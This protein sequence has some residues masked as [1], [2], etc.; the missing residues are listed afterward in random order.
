MK[1][2]KTKGLFLTLIGLASVFLFTS[3]TLNIESAPVVANAQSSIDYNEKTITSSFASL[4]GKYEE[5]FVE[6]F[7]PFL[8]SHIMCNVYRFREHR[9]DSSKSVIL[10]SE[11]YHSPI[12][13]N[14]EVKPLEGCISNTT[15]I[16][17]MTS[18]EIVYR[19]AGVLRFDTRSDFRHKGYRDLYSNSLEPI[20]TFVLDFREFYEHNEYPSFFSIETSPHRE[21]LT[22]DSI[23]ITYDSDLGY[24]NT[25]PYPSGYN[26]HRLPAIKFNTTNTKYENYYFN[27]DYSSYTTE[28]PLT[29]SQDTWNFYT[30]TEG[31]NSISLYGTNSHAFSI[32]EPA[33]YTRNDGYVLAFGD[34]YIQN[35]TYYEFDVPLR[36]GKG[37]GVGRLVLFTQGLNAPG[38]IGEPLLVFTD[39]H[40]ATFCE[41]LN[42]SINGV[43]A[44]GPR[45]D[46]EYMK[47]GRKW[48]PAHTVGLANT[49]TS[50]KPSELKPTITITDGPEVW[51]NPNESY[52][53]NVKVEDFAIND[54]VTFEVLE[55][56][57]KT[58]YPGAGGEIYNN[59]A[60]IAKIR[61]VLEVQNS[62]IVKSN[63]ITVHASKVKELKVSGTPLKT[64]YYDGHLFDPTGLE[65]TA[66][67]E[68][69]SI[70]NVSTDACVW[71]NP[72]Y[73]DEYVHLWQSSINCKYK[74]ACT[75][76]NIPEIKTIYGSDP[77]SL[78]IVQTTGQILAKTK[79]KL[80]VIVEP[81][82]AGKLV[83]WSIEYDRQYSQPAEIDKSGV[84]S[85]KDRLCKFAVVATSIFDSSVKDKVYFE[86]VNDVGYG[87]TN[88]QYDL[89][90]GEYL[91]GTDSY[92]YDPSFT[93]NNYVVSTHK[94]GGK[95]MNPRI[96]SKFLISKSNTEGNYYHIK[97][98]DNNKYIGFSS[99]NDTL[100]TDSFSPI[101]TYIEVSNGTCKI[102]NADKSKVFQYNRI[103]KCFGLYP[104]ETQT[105]LT[106][107]R[108]IETGSHMITCDGFIEIYMHMNDY[109]Q[110]LGRCKQ[111]GYDYYGKAKQAFNMLSNKDRY[112][113]ATFSRFADAFERLKA[114]ARANDEEII[115]DEM[116]NVT[117][118]VL[119]S[120][121]IDLKQDNNLPIILCVTLLSGI[122]FIAFVLIKRKHARI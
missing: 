73:F 80:D 54:R 52:Y 25:E 116:G 91:I 69:G 5:N 98:V 12:K 39:D 79:T 49:G 64:E 48:S 95:I 60:G 17:G 11:D 59:G 32:H 88:Q 53:L 121:F 62:E 99:A 100:L 41:Y 1:I 76:Y 36:Y 77:V 105:E 92:L 87:G 26:V 122:S 40:Y 61:A 27:S 72:D 43:A 42:Y 35:Q 50:E 86:I 85:T 33:G 93:L 75:T 102:F 90:N 30:L 119:N 31:I 113:F 6:D 46:A 110:E 34:Y 117:Y 8:N 44:F 7:S 101:D 112:Q 67:Y 4:E 2:K 74:K 107:H 20:Q 15:P 82:D 106:L 103:E 104:D 13:F 81:A 28:G 47:T 51:M 19:G 71:E 66:T 114:W 58:F 109:T 111:P 94:S 10:A 84:L 96:T 14:G 38:Y 108:K 70:E 115:V 89:L 21:D 118:N 45:F 120:N 97:R 65:V 9:R 57:N 37:R 29:L 68:D 78:K 24:C 83:N 18:I 23:K 22:I 3:S 16:K 55:D 56:S 63:I